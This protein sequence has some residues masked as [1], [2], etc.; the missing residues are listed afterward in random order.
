MLRRWRSSEKIARRRGGS[1]RAHAHDVEA[2]DALADVGVHA[3]EVAE[4][5]FFQ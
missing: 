4:N 2:G 3:L 5:A 1:W